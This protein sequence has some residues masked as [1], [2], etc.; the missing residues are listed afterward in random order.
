MSIFRREMDGPS[1]PAPRV[2]ERTEPPSATTTHI[3]QGT[4][5]NGEV[6]GAKAVRLD[7]ELH[8]KVIVDSSVVIG[9]AGE[10]QG[11]IQARSVQLGGRVVGNIRGSERV[12]L[13]PSAK[14]EGDISAPRVTIAEGAFFK[15]QVEMRGESRRESA[16]GAGAP[17][18]RREERPEGGPPQRSAEASRPGGSSGSGGGPGKRRR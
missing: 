9:P 8:G 2:Q 10:L 3:A 11:E 17:P 1:A 16:P 12:E 14:M 7:G 6:T 4:K 13:T 18:P 15:G 5:V